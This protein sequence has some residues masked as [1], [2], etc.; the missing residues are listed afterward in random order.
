MSIDDHPKHGDVE[1]EVSTVTNGRFIG[2]KCGHMTKT[3][4]K[5]RASC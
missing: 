5:T 1:T 3:K 4:I 2:I